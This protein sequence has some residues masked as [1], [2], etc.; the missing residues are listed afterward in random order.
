MLFKVS[1]KVTDF[2]NKVLLSETPSATFL[3]MQHIACLYF[4]LCL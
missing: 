4:S 2:L 3:I 1:N